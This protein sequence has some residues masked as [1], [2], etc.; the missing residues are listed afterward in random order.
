MSKY[1]VEAKDNVRFL[2]TLE[3]HFKNLSQGNSFQI[4]LDTIPSLMTALHMVWIIS[5][6]YNKD[7]RMVP[8]ME[9]IAWEVAE[10]VSR[11]INVRKIL[12]FVVHVEP[13]LSLKP[14]YI[15]QN[16]GEIDF[17]AEPNSNPD[18]HQRILANCL[19]NSFP[20]TFVLL[21]TIT[22]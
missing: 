16:I 3:R 9:R 2:S 5:R 22:F 4:V 10:R 18:C 17:R 6:H 15:P 1:Y 14:P 8:L 12:R 19:K 7:E 20:L 21:I 13:V 11:V